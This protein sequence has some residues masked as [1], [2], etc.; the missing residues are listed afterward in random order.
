M[1]K[2]LLFL[3]FLSS[4]TFLWTRF[5]SPIRFED[6]KTV[7]NSQAE[8]KEKI[9]ICGVG[10]NIEEAVPNL[11][12]SVNRLGSKFLDYRAIIY[13]NNSTDGTKDL[14]KK[15]AD[16]DPHVIYISE[17]LS[18]KTLSGESSMKMTHRIEKI[19]RARNIVMDIAMQ[20]NFDDYK[21]VLW[22][23]L[24]HRKPWDVGPIVETI[25]HPQED[26]DAVLAYGAYD[27]FAMRSPKWPIGFELLGDFY[28]KN[29]DT[30]R[31]GFVLDRDGPWE[32]VY[33]A[34]GGFG[35]YKRE[36]IRGCRYS[37]V[38]TKDLEKAAAIWLSLAKR[39][40]SC[41]FLKEYEAFLENGPVID[42]KGPFLKDREK[43]PDRLGM[44]LLKGKI[45]WFSCTPKTTL[46]W[47]C[48]HIPFHAS[49]IVHGKDKIF[50][51]P[52]IHS[53]P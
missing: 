39:Q 47:T 31:N 1:R 37:A 46:P 42:L 26:W 28:W 22:A 33:S 45:V 10:R 40:E 50:I 38:A 49:M 8:V 41:P 5:S 25:L 51:N 30:F 34:F 36:S 15:W 19:A 27:L 21:Y 44:R 24:D 18:A 12:E 20:K 48:E 4:F 9:L 29:L 52:K 53:D 14:L 16:G 7:L 6:P 11:I 3:A 2:A 13:E 32:K 43:Y 35:I 17:Q 23:D